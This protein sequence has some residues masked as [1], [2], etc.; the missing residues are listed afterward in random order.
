MPRTERFGEEYGETLHD[1]FV[2]GDYFRSRSFAMSVVPFEDYKSIKK[3][4]A[5]TLVHGL[6]SMRRLKRYL[7][8]EQTS[9]SDAMR[10]GTAI[11]CAVLEPEKFALQYA[12]MP[13]FSQ[14]EENVTDKGQRSYSAATKYV[15]QCQEEW[16]CR[17]GDKTELDAWEYATC[18]RVFESIREC[19][20]IV[21]MLNR[22]DK[23]QTFEGVICG[24]ECKGRVDF[25]GDVVGDLKTTTSVE[26]RAFSRV[27][28]NLE[29]GFRL[30]VYRELVRQNRGDLPVGI[31]AVETSGDFDRCLYRVPDEL[32]DYS[33]EQ[34]NLVLMQYRMCLDSGLWPGVDKGF[35][36]VD[37]P[38]PGWAMK[39]EL[40]WSH[41]ENECVE[42]TS[43]EVEQVF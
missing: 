34:V 6:K 28:F 14:D 43:E 23:E 36:A 13:N 29:Y 3:M 21:D 2:G 1:E 30:A 35:D 4:N 33:M 37:F 38:V 24:V 27:F 22:S 31:L 5:S 12:V 8:G 18:N 20:H 40:D 7:D 26:T 15:K 32:L 42:Q 19:P 25:I 16:R 11:H 17:N 39:A 10:L 41:M 9:E